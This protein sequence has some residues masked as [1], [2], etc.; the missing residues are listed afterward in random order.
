M[1]EAHS[2]KF[3]LAGWRHEWRTRKTPASL[4]RGFAA[5]TC[6][7]L[8]GR[9]FTYGI[10]IPLG[11]PKS[12][13][14]LD[15]GYGSGLWLLAMA[16]LGWRDLHGFDIDANPENRARLEQAGVNVRSGDFVKSDFPE[17]SFDCIRLEHVF[18]HLPNPVEVLLKC[19]SLLKEGG[20]LLLSYPTIE[21][22]AFA[23][24]G[25]DYEQLDLPRHITHQ[26]VASTRFLLGRTGFA[27]ERIARAPMAR[28]FGSSVNARLQRRK[29]RIPPILFKILGPAYYAISK[30]ARR[31]ENIMVIARKQSNGSRVL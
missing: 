27:A 14:M 11:L 5:R 15:V 1:R 7:W 17:N 6:E 13:R 20:L 28:C 22:L 2:L 21:S 3:R 12:S 25:E 10:A 9:T 29:I 8:A 23:A 24:A 19:R 30:A 16:E 31:G 4:A 26:T 18:E